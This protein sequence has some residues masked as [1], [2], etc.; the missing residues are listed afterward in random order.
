MLSYKPIIR[1]TYKVY[2]IY[3]FHRLPVCEED[4]LPAR[5]LLQRFLPVLDVI[6]NDLRSL[7]GGEVAAD[8][9]DEIALRVYTWI[10]A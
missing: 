4:L 9:L 10:L 6:R 7:V 2:K 8:G 1:Y 3:C 5:L